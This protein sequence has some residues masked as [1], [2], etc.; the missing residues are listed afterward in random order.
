MR[1]QLRCFQQTPTRRRCT[2]LRERTGL[3]G[4]AHVTS[5]LIPE[6]CCDDGPLWALHSCGLPESRVSR[7]RTRPQPPRHAHECGAF[8][9]GTRTRKGREPVRRVIISRLY[10]RNGVPGADTSG[11]SLFPETE[12]LCIQTFT[13]V[14]WQRPSPPPPPPLLGMSLVVPQPCPVLQSRGQLPDDTALSDV[15]KGKCVLFPRPRT[16]RPRPHPLPW[17]RPRTST[18]TQDTPSRGTEWGGALGSHPSVQHLLIERCSSP[19]L[20]RQLSLSTGGT[21]TPV[22]V[23]SHC[24]ASAQGVEEG[25]A[26]YA[27]AWGDCSKQQASI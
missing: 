18:G 10:F 14:T 3:L 26:C 4:L 17:C 22:R 11:E 21:R 12:R 16:A 9:H 7:L 19:S 6:S 2:E 15:Q 23:Y 20:S 5:V 1:P 24:G 27:R 25:L 8:G 13:E